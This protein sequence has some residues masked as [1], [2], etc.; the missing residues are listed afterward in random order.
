LLGAVEG[1]FERVQVGN[2]D[3]TVV[4]NSVVGTLLGALVGVFVGAL[5]GALVGTLVG[6][7]VGSGVNVKI[8]GGFRGIE[9]WLAVKASDVKAPEA[10]TTRRE[11]IATKRIMVITACSNKFTLCSKCC[12]F[13]GLIMS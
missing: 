11:R 6:A 7:E 9:H 10:L 1:D 2:I 4:G 3:G 5:V 8:T 12:I 13:E